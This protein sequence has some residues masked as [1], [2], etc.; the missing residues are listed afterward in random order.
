[1]LEIQDKNIKYEDKTKQVFK[2]IFSSVKNYAEQYETLFVAIVTIGSSIISTIINLCFYFYKVGYCSY[3]GIDESI[4]LSGIK[5]NSL[6]LIGY[7]LASYSLIIL[8]N[9]LAYI[10][11]ANRKFL[12]FCLPWSSLVAIWNFIYIVKNIG[13]GGFGKNVFF[14]IGGVIIVAIAIFINTAMIIMLLFL[15]VLGYL[16]M[17]PSRKIE[18]NHYEIKL[19]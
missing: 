11:Y 2:S 16:W 5:E 3:F 14:L 9:I 4:I 6:L 18:L 17:F 1:M 19:E 13:F 8:V 7:Y 12:W 15:P 10:F